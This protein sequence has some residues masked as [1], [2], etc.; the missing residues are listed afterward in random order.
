MKKKI[1]K[2]QIGIN[3]IM[4]IIIIFF[5]TF[6]NYDIKN[7]EKLYDEMEEIYFSK[8]DYYFEGYLVEKTFLY[9]YRGNEFEDFNVYLIKMKVD[10]VFIG[11]NLRSKG[12]PFVG[13]Y[14][15]K[16]DYVYFESNL[17]SSK[18]E[19]QE[20]SPTKIVLSSITEKV[21]LSGGY[22]YRMDI[23]T[24]FEKPFTDIDTIGCVIF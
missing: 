23:Q 16:D 7:K 12:E 15:P 2:G 5:F 9:N 4:F 14:S 8:V 24:K 1:T 19:Y 21:H 20:Y 10:S 13:I 22:E 6:V 18:E 11:K 17:Y 3:I